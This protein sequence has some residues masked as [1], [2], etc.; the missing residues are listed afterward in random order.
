MLQ[1]TCLA[2]RE[3]QRGDLIPID[4]SGGWRCFIV[5][6]GTGRRHSRL[7]YPQLDPSTE[8]TDKARVQLNSLN[9]RSAYDA[10]V[11]EA[12]ASDL[13]GGRKVRVT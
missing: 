12:G 7:R 4:A 3:R 6:S 5:R 13:A 2:D 11:D 8:G 1:R 9:E 10:T